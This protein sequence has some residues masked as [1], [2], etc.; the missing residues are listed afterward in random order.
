M[1]FTQK[2]N[3]RLNELNDRRRENITPISL[4]KKRGRLLNEQEIDERHELS[5]R[6]NLNQTHGLRLQGGNK[7]YYASQIAE[8]IDWIEQNG[9]RQYSYDDIK[10]VR[11]GKSHYCHEINILLK[12]GGVSDFKRFNDLKTLLGFIE[13]FNSCKDDWRH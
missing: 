4:K 1:E 11:I 6:K 9:I 7:Y 5:F 8:F 13:G 3:D 12:S 10:E 2:Q